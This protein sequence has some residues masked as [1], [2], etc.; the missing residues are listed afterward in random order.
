MSS[1]PSVEVVDLHKNNEKVD[2]ND[3]TEIA[4]GM[5]I[6]DCVLL[7]SKLEDLAAENLD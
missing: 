6:Y 1:M 4:I 7:K 3:L 5:L 2:L